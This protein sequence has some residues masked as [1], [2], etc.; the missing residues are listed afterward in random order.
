V[1]HP[2]PTGV[3][4]DVRVI[5]R[6][7]RTETSGSRDGRL[8]VRLAAPPIDGAANEALVR[9]VAAR[10]GVPARQV[11]IVSGQ[12]GRR[13]RVHVTGVTAAQAEA[14]LLG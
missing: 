9:F 4:I 8:L 10:L 3:A 12:R 2:I 14:A 11:T 7:S 5:A 1:F 13:K 6:A